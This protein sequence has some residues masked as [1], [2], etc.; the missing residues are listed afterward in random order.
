MR[1]LPEDHDATVAQ[2]ALA[3]LITNYRDTVVAIPGASKPHHAVESAAAMSIALT[4]E[5]TAQLTYLSDA[6]GS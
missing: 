6:C 5:E 4:T 2:I 3:W 1:S